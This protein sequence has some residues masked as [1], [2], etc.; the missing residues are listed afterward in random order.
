MAVYP[1]DVRIA[2]QLL[3]QQARIN[4]LEAR[5]RE[6]LAAEPIFGAEALGALVRSVWVEWAREQPNPKPSWLIPWEDL[7]PGQREVDMRIGEAVAAA[8]RKRIRSAPTVHAP[9]RTR[10]TPMWLPSSP[11]KDPLP[12]P[13]VCGAERGDGFR[14]ASHP[15]AVTCTECRIALAVAAER[16]RTGSREKDK[17]DALLVIAVLLGKLGGEAKITDAELAAENSIIVRFPEVDGYTLSCR[18][19]QPGEH[20]LALGV[21]GE[22]DNA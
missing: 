12:I 20:A 21:W 2:K 6:A 9:T 14:L 8:E 17:R 18:D 1:D 11:A 10:W 15:G 3:D 13:A 5:E 22:A 19:T 4:E 7:D 16:E